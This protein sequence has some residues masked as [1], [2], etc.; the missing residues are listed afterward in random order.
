MHGRGR[1]ALYTVVMATPFL[2]LPE[3]KTEAED[4]YDAD[5]FFAGKVRQSRAYQQKYRQAF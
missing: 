2:G 3:L 1:R 5:N 4:D